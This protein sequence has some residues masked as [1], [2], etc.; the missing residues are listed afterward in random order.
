MIYDILRNNQIIDTVDGLDNVNNTIE[1][2]Q[3]DNALYTF[4][5]HKTRRLEP[6]YCS[7]FCNAQ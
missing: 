4:K 5:K 7:W 1:S 2:L 6:E 3:E